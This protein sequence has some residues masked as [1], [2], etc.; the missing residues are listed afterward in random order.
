MLNTIKSTQLQNGY[1]ALIIKQC[2]ERVRYMLQTAMEYPAGEFEMV[3]MCTG[4]LGKE[5]RENISVDTRL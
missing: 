1:L 3:S 5:G 2:L 4:L